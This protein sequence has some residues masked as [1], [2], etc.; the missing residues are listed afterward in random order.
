[1]SCSEIIKRN[2]LPFSNYLKFISVNARSIPAKYSDFRYLVEESDC[3]VIAVAETWI[4][5]STPKSHYMIPSYNTVLLNRVNKR[6]GGVAIYLREGIQYKT[7]N[8]NNICN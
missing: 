4:T 2:L 8:I 5:A 6:G 3:D 1:M 7:I